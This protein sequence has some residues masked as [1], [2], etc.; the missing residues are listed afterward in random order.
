MGKPGSAA[1]ALD[2]VSDLKRAGL[3]V[4]AIFMVGVGGDRWAAAHTRDSVELLARLPFGEGD[5]VYLSPFVEHPGS[6]YAAKAAEE[7]IRA[8]G[9]GEVERQFAALREASFRAHPRIRV[10]RYDLREFVY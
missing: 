10:A 4:A 6:A 5:I 8:S 1:A 9:A 7:G 2:L 3:A